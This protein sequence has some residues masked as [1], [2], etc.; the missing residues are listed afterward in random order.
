MGETKH[1]SEE[2][3]ELYALG[4]LPEEEAVQIEEHLFLCDSCRESLDTA[5]DF[6]VG[7]RDHLRQNP[8]PPKRSVF[9]WLN[10]SAPRFALAGAFAV[11]IL[12]L[13]IFWLRPSARIAPLATLQLTA[14]RG[15]MQTTGTAR[16][17]DL[18]LADA[19]AP[20]GRFRVE[21]V[22]GSGTRMWEG[23]SATDAGQVEVKIR[24]RLSPGDY[25]VRLYS[26][27]GELLHEYGFCVRG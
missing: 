26:A 8:V 27:S 21:V 16:E 25:F 4:R 6:A 13:G 23:A 19:S 18:T 2:R 22:N 5:A 15:E 10:L 20:G 3:L 1:H 11:A 7:V 14:M 9:D 24:Q 12:A 17:F